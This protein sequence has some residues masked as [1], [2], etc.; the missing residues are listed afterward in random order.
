MDL[1]SQPFLSLLFRGRDPVA[2]FGTGK[3]C[4]IQHFQRPEYIACREFVELHAGHSLHDLAENDDIDVAILTNG[5]GRGEGLLPTNHP[6]GLLEVTP[7]R[8]VAKGSADS[9]CVREQVPK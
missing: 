5:S 9:G 2:L 3:K 8:T 4:R 1:S 7:I 6:Q